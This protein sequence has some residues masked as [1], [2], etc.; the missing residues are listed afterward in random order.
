[1]PS[2]SAIGATLSSGFALFTHRILFIL[3]FY[4]FTNQGVWLLLYVVQLIYNFRKFGQK[5]EII[6]RCNRLQVL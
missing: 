5:F 2:G 1:M 4:V 6:S 3:K